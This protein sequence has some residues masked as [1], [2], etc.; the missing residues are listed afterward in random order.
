MRDAEDS[1]TARQERSPLLSQ[2][3]PDVC[4]GT[5]FDPAEI[6]SYGAIELPI[7]T[8]DDII[9]NH[10]HPDSDAVVDTTLAE[11]K[12]GRRV[13]YWSLMKDN[14]NFRWYLMSSLVTH[15]GE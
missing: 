4:I 3:S 11:N 10:G 6:V 2:M 5:A 12:S 15:A 1:T 14:E 7:H 13:S 9:V 8:D